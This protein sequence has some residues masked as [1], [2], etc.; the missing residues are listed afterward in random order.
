[1][2]SISE[3]STKIVRLV[4]RD[5]RGALLDADLVHVKGYLFT[6]GD[7]KHTFEI[8][9]G[10][11]SG[12][13]IIEGNVRLRMDENFPVGQMKV[14][15]Q[16]FVADD[17]SSDEIV[18]ANEQPISVQIVESGS[19]IADKQ[20]EVWADIY[21]PIESNKIINP[22][23]V[24]EQWVKDYVAE[25]IKNIPQS[26]GANTTLSNVTDAD[27]EKKGKASSFAQNDLE[28]VDLG[29]L[30]EKGVAA[31]LAKDDMSNV[32]SGDIVNRISSSDA[33]NLVKHTPAFIALSKKQHPAVAGLTPDEI[34]NLFY[35]NRKEVQ[36]A[37]DLTQEEYKQSSCLLLITQ[38][39]GDTTKVTQMLPPASQNQIIMVEM[40][41]STDKPAVVEYI[42]YTGQQIN[43][44]DDFKVT[45]KEGGFAGM[46]IPVRNINSYEWIPFEDT[47]KTYLSA[48][49]NRGNVI[50]DVKKFVFHDP[51]YLE[52]NDDTKETNVKL[53]DV[54]I[55]FADGVL[56]QTFKATRIQ[57]LDKSIHI[58]P[59]PDGQTPDGE[60]LFVADLSVA[61]KPQDEGIYAEVGWDTVWNSAFPKSRINY[62]NVLVKGGETVRID[63]DTKSFNLGD[64]SDT[65][66][67][68]VTGGTT[69]LVAIGYKPNKTARSTITQNGY[70]RAELVDNT[71]APILDMYGS[72]M[73]GQNDYEV[74]QEERPMFYVGLCKVAA[75]TLVH[76]QFSI[77]FPT[78]ELI[79][80]GSDSFVMFQAVTAEGGLGRAYD[81]FVERTGIRVNTDKKYYGKNFINLA[82]MLTE[83]LYVNE[84]PAE[85]NNFGLNAFLSAKTPYKFGI[86]NNELVLQGDNKVA[87]IV[88]IG[89][90][91]SGIDGRML[92]GKEAKVTALMENTACDVE[93]AVL[94][95]MGNKAD[96]TKPELV[97]FT[98]DEAEFPTGWIPMSKF[99]VALDPTQG[100]QKHTGILTLPTNSETFAIVAYPLNPA[101]GMTL[102][103][104]DI[105]VDI[106]PEHTHVII[107]DNSNAINIYLEYELASVSFETKTPSGLAGLRYTAQS[108]DTKVPVGVINGEMGLFFNNHA[109]SDQDTGDAS[110]E[111]DLEAVK[112]LK[113]KT[114]KYSVRKVFNEG[115]TDSKVEFW[116]AKV[117]ADGTFTEVQGSRITDTIEAKRVVPKVFFSQ[118]FSFVA[119]KGDS[120]RVFMKSDEDDGFY[121]QSGTDGIPLFSLA[122]E[123][124][125]I[126]EVPRLTDFSG[127]QLMDGD[128][129]V[130]DPESYTLQID[131]KTG[132]IT[133][134]KK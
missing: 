62:G 88:S 84:Y 91:Y 110:A 115:N 50:E 60:T 41:N 26:G 101:I 35:T 86:E 125:E 123:V 118:P 102:K 34:R 53:G 13:L 79:T 67:P 29:K 109:W 98:G 10:V 17:Y 65:D 120:F 130:K 32:K 76:V 40:V 103:F 124:S 70:L 127:I 90:L 131:V 12:C 126:E 9:K 80:V 63:E 24:T 8:N 96:Y 61:S 6:R 66:D 74:G 31:G 93:F 36:G 119:N 59:L 72:P 46:F 89:W 56:N 52:H 58:A 21:L 111:G 14:Y 100:V 71:G 82:Q 75:D 57:S 106:V 49:D 4:L 11:V 85:Y 87:P 22:K 20:G 68:S 129:E 45:I 95:Y 28:D 112:D 18:M 30:E 132:A 44:V 19:S 81:M 97:G 105:Q 54:P 134:K 122:M 73:A 69:F 48:S 23:S 128:T 78:E 47:Q 7:I 51:I 64:I 2:K 43:G 33:D 37:V 121:L 108:T 114:A 104:K 5:K 39:V 25:Q 94:E 42:P 1:M 38:I 16:T 27:F 113:I 77:N 133:V 92:K 117:N 55:M 83:T 99:K 107:T 3:D 15:S 116:L